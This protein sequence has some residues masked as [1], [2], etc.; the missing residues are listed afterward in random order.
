M[1]RPRLPVGRALLR[2]LAGALALAAALLSLA[3]GAVALD[4]LRDR[5]DR[6]DV[7]VVLGSALWGDVPSPGLAARLE[8]GAEAWRRGSSSRAD[9]SPAA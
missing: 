7:A 8:R 1:E 6:P 2:R 3:C 5:P 9:L 4:G